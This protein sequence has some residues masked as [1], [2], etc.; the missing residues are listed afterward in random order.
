M[1]VSRGGP[2]KPSHVDRLNRRNGGS[3]KEHCLGKGR[4]PIKASLE[5]RPGMPLVCKGKR[6][7]DQS[8]SVII[9]FGQSPSGME[10]E[11]REVGLRGHLKTQVRQTEDVTRAQTVQSR[12]GCGDD[13]G[14]D[15]ERRQ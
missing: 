8:N 7:S 4:D 9:R 6:G 2:G 3:R 15:S 11:L 14:W 13:R 12:R 5:L 10:D 1:S